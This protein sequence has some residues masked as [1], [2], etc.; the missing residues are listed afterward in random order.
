MNYIEIYRKQ[1]SDRKF[2]F[3]FVL[4]FWLPGL[5]LQYYKPD[6][7]FIP[8]NSGILGL[9]FMGIGY[10]FILKVVKNS[11]CPACKQSPGNHWV[12]KS[13]KNC[14]EQLS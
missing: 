5:L 14:G 3:V 2:N 9:A 8:I 7:S 6:I 12:V 10:F 13:C 11:K 4:L 1:A